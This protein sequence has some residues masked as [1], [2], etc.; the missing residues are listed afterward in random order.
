MN[1]FVYLWENKKNKKMYLGSHKGNVN[2]SYIGSGVYFKKAFEKA[3]ENFNRTILYYGNKFREI[4]DALL[5]S[6]NAANNDKFYN[7]KNDAVGGWAHCQ[8]KEIKEKRGKS[9]SEVKKG[10][11]PA[12]SARDKSGRKNP[13]YGKKHSDVT[14]LK[15]SEK[16]KGVANKKY[17]VIEITTGMRFEKVIDAAK[18]YGIASSTMSVL[19]RNKPIT[20][21]KCKNK[22]FQYV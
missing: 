10:K 8:T 3:P 20:R 16:R 21:G 11:A 12:C 9:I 5:K 18:Y 17:P 14:K 22:I 15:I 19:I 7:L 2:D 13:M 6:V 1:G 4:E